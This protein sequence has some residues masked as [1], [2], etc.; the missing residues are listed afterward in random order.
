MRKAKKKAKKQPVQWYVLWSDY[1]DKIRSIAVHLKASGIN[2]RTTDHTHYEGHRALEIASTDI[3]R[4]R[5]VLRLF[6]FNDI[7]KHCVIR[8][9]KS[10]SGRLFM[11]G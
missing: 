6:G 11:G 8:G 4:A 3:A 2:A 5:H 9:F 10:Q 1:A 7:A